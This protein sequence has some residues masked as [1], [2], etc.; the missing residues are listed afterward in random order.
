MCV[1]RNMRTLMDTTIRDGLSY[2]AIKFLYLPRLFEVVHK[3]PGGLCSL[4]TATCT[5]SQHA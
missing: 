4:L 3:Y 1:D 2:P 5:A